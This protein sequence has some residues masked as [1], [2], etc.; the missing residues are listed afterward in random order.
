[1]K[2]RSPGVG[3]DRGSVLLETAFAIPVLAAIALALVWVVSLG[4]AYA[5]ALDTAQTAARAVSRG[6]PAPLP[7]SDERLDV[8]HDAGLVDVTVTR[9]E[10]G[11]A[12][13]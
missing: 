12:H 7:H 9:D 4:A 13:V 6:A 5:Y 10:I 2:P 3:R 8:I 11:R 1:M